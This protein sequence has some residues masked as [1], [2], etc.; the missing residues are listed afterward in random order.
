MT[1][2]RE[3]VGASESFAVEY[4]GEKGSW[5]VSD[6]PGEEGMHMFD[7]RPRFLEVNPSAIPN[8][9]PPLPK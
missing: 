1:G 7:L 5:N 9:I 6:I 8:P 4:M 3:P 2:C